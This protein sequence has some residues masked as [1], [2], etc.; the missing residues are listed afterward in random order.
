MHELSKVRITQCP[1]PTPDPRDVGE[2]ESLVLDTMAQIVVELFRHVGAEKA[3]DLP[4]IPVT[5][6]LE[7]VKSF[8]TIDEI[9]HLFS[10]NIRR[11]RE[12]GGYQDELTRQ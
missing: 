1:P 10:F 9:S 6:R 4:V 3:F 7:V 8:G 2:R 11:L 5:Q 12:T